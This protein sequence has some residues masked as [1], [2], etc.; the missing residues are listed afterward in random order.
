MNGVI[1]SV[2]ELNIGIVSACLPTLR[3]I[4]SYIFQ[5]YRQAIQK[6]K[7][8]GT[9]HE[10]PGIRLRGFNIPSA[11]EGYGKLGASADLQGLV[12]PEIAHGYANDWDVYSPRRPKDRSSSDYACNSGLNESPKM[13]ISNPHAITV[14]TEIGVSTTAGREIM[15]N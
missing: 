4:C 15:Q 1:W 2:V 13:P 10:N 14:T 9:P 11:G 3:P 5:G 6:K 7:N 12:H 8:A